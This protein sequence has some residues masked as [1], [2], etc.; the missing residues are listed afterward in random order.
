MFHITEQFAA[1]EIAIINPFLKTIISPWLIYI[2][3]CLNWR[4][5][6]YK[7]INYMQ[8]HYIFRTAVTENHSE[9][10]SWKVGSV[11][12]AALPYI[13]CEIELPFF[14]STYAFIAIKFDSITIMNISLAGHCPL[15]QPVLCSFPLGLCMPLF[16]QPRQLWE[17]TESA[18][19]LWPSSTHRPDPQ[20]SWHSFWMTQL[21]KFRKE[22]KISKGSS[23]VVG[24]YRAF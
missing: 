8:S 15:L 24:A 1:L 7:D 12:G 9:E 18:G 10:K 6:T 20:G 19:P 17:V 13:L 16:L 4:Q 14:P 3:C 5:S 22:N 11:K 23:L 21:R 2:K